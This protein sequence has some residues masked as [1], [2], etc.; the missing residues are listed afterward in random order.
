MH[1]NACSHFKRDFH[2]AYVI[3]KAIHFVELIS[4]NLV[5]KVTT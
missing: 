5:Y 3:T 2:E 4:Y 1:T